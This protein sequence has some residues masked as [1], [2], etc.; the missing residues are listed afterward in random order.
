MDVQTAIIVIDGIPFECYG[1]FYPAFD[2]GRDE[3]SHDAYWD[4]DN[5]YIGNQSV[6]GAGFIPW[7]QLE[8]EIVKG[9]EDGSDE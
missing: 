2:G 4:W 6:L 5:C 8:S 1:T 3:P 9:F 7:Q